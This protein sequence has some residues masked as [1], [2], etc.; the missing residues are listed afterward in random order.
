MN[1]PTILDCAIA[2]M[3]AITSLTAAASGSNPALPK[4][5]LDAMS[6]L[7][8]WSGTWQGDGWA[9]TGPGQRQTF[10]ITEQVT[11]KLGGTVV[12]VEGRGTSTAPDGTEIVTHE[13]LGVV[14]YDTAS[15][16]YN[17][18]TH[19]RRGRANEVE[20]EID[21]DGIM[22]WAFRDDHSGSLLRFE[23]E[24]SGDTWHETGQVSPDGGDN[25]YP[26]LE[27]TLKR[28]QAGTRTE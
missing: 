20:L 25:W 6:R 5:Q 12:L 8:H 23:I 13:A 17:F 2:A 24:I 19:D 21:E 27:M 18:Q 9:M 7:H 15:G 4:Q 1:R 14:Y 28:Q 22:R 11:K 16:G 26:M 10:E 3:L